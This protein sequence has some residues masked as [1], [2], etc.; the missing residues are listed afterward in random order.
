MDDDW[1]TLILGN[2]HIKRMMT[3]P[4]TWFLFAVLGE[5]SKLFRGLFM[6]VLC[7]LCTHVSPTFAQLLSHLLNYVGHF[8]LLFWVLLVRSYVPSFFVGYTIG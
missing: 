5:I 8:T 2:P 3:L 4:I 6:L 1:G 7:N